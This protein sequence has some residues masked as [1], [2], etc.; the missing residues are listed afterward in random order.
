M[1]VPLSRAT[2]CSFSRSSG[3]FVV[4]VSKS[5]KIFIESG[6]RS[7]P[8]FRNDKDLFSLFSRWSD[9]NAIQATYWRGLHNLKS[10]SK[11]RQTLLGYLKHSFCS[12]VLSSSLLSLFTRSNHKRSGQRSMCK[13]SPQ[14][15]HSPQATVLTPASHTATMNTPIDEEDLL[16]EKHL[17]LL[18]SSSIHQDQHEVASTPVFTTPILKHA[19]A[20]FNQY[21]FL[22]G[23]SNIL[24]VNAGRGKEQPGEDPRIFFNISAPSSAF[25]CGSQG[26]GKSH[27]LSC[28][29][30][31]CL[32]KS[33]VSTLDSPLVSL[34]RRFPFKQGFFLSWM[35]F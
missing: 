11:A 17:A 15:S 26:S 7:C 1:H 34:P 21:G 5:D 25:I 35:R 18:T 14:H 16:R 13:S 6:K 32:M 4:T 23:L 24:D 12:F 33:D 19:R 9:K 20:S 2:G 31:N 27:T 10:E 28:L 22:A 29:L 8:S 3:S 30:E